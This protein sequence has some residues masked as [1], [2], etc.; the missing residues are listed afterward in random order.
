MN[1]SCLPPANSKSQS[2]DASQAV[3]ACN[4]CKLPSC[5]LHEQFANAS[6]CVVC[7]D[8]A[9]PVHCS[10]CYPCS[11]TQSHPLCF[12]TCKLFVPQVLDQIRD[13]SI[14]FEVDGKKYHILVIDFLQSPV[15]INSWSAVPWQSRPL[16]YAFVLRKFPLLFDHPV[17]LAGV[18][19]RIRNVYDR[20]FAAIP[21]PQGALDV[22]IEVISAIT[23]SF[24]TFKEL[25]SSIGTDAYELLMNLFTTVTKVL[26]GV[27]V[28]A[29]TVA[30]L[31]SYINKQAVKFGAT[32][33]DNSA[34][35]TDILIACIKMMIRVLCNYRPEQLAMEVA[36]DLLNIP[37]LHKLYVYF[38]T[39]KPPTSDSND[40]YFDE[41]DEEY[42][43]SYYNAYPQSAGDI[44]AIFA[45]TLVT[46]INYFRSDV[47]PTLKSFSDLVRVFQPMFPKE[48]LDICGITK[49][50]EIVN[51]V[52]IDKNMRA[53]CPHSAGLVDMLASYK[54]PY[55]PWITTRIRSEYHAA[56]AEISAHPNRDVATYWKSRIGLFS[57]YLPKDSNEPVDR[58]QPDAF[59]FHGAPGQGKSVVTDK[60]LVGALRYC[61]LKGYVPED[62]TLSTFRCNVSCANK[63]WDS[64]VGQ[65]V[66]VFNDFLQQKESPGNT[67]GPLFLTTVDT[68]PMA[69]PI[70][71]ANRKGIPV[72][73]MVVLM[74]GNI[75]VNDW[76]R[77][78]TQSNNP[79]A[80]KRRVTYRISVEARKKNVT[81]TFEKAPNFS[82]DDQWIFN[83]VETST[84]RSKTLRFADILAL[85][86][87][88]IE[89][90]MTIPNPCTMISAESNDLIDYL[91]NAS[92]SI[93]AIFSEREE[94]SSTE[95]NPPCPNPSAPP[96]LSA[97][98]DINVIFGPPPTTSSLPRSYLS[99]FFDE[100]MDREVEDIRDGASTPSLSEYE[101]TPHGVPNT[102]FK[103]YVLA[104]FAQMFEDVKKSVGDFNDTVAGFTK[105]APLVGTHTDACNHHD[106][107]H[108]RVALFEDAFRIGC[109]AFLFGTLAFLGIKKAKEI[110]HPMFGKPDIVV[111]PPQ[112][113]DLP[114]IPGYIVETITH[115]G[116]QVLIYRKKPAV[117][118]PNG[119]LLQDDLLK[120]IRNPM[121]PD[122]REAQIV[123]SLAQSQ[124][125][126][127][128]SPGGSQVCWAFFVNSSHFIIANHCWR[129]EMYVPFQPSALLKI[130]KGN[131]L[132][133][134]DKDVCLIRVLDN[135]VPGCR[136]QVTKFCESVTSPM[137]AIIPQLSLDEVFTSSGIA[138]P[139]YLDT[140][141]YECYS[142][143]RVGANGD[144]GLVY[145]DRSSS[146]P[147]RVLGI[148]V[149]GNSTTSFVA[150]VLASW[151]R[152]C[153]KETIA[154]YHPD[155]P[156]EKH[157]LST[158]GIPT[159]P[160]FSPIKSAYV[161]VVG[162]SGP[163]ITHGIARLGKFPRTM[164]D[165][166]VVYVS[167]LINGLNKWALKR[168]NLGNFSM[169]VDLLERMK[170]H[171]APIFNEAWLPTFQ[172]SVVSH[173]DRMWKA[174]DRSKAAGYS[175]VSA[176]KRVLFEDSEEPVLTAAALSA[177]DELEQ[178]LLN[179]EPIA[180][181]KVVSLKDEKLP[182]QKVIEGRTRLFCS[183][184]VFEFLLGR[185]YF[186]GLVSGLNKNGR[187]YGYPCATDPEQLGE[188]LSK[189]KNK[190][191]L[192]VDIKGQDTSYIADAWIYF[193]MVLMA[194]PAGRNFG[195]IVYNHP[196][197][198]PMDAVNYIRYQLIWHIINDPFVANRWAFYCGGLL[199]SGHLLTLV[200]NI[201]NSSRTKLLLQLFF[202][203]VESI[204]FGDDSWFGFDKLEDAQAAVE[205]LLK[206][207]VQVGF[208][209]VDQDK[210]DQDIQV[211][212][213]ENAVFCGRRF[214][215]HPI[216]GN[217][218]YLIPER[219]MKSV[220]FVKSTDYWANLRQSLDNFALES[221]R[222]PQ[223]Y[224]EEV[225]AFSLFGVCVRDYILPWQVGGHVVTGLS[226][227]ASNLDEFIRL[228]AIAADQEARVI[229]AEPQGLDD[230]VSV[231]G[232]S[233]AYGDFV[234]TAEVE[235]V[236][237]ADCIYPQIESISKERF[238]TPVYTEEISWNAA[239]AAGTLIHDCKCLSEYFDNYATGQYELA[240]GALFR[241]TVNVHVTISV[242]A[243][244]S[245]TLIVAAAPCQDPPIDQYAASTLIHGQIN[246][247]TDSTCL[248]MI[249]YQRD[250]LYSQITA[251][252]VGDAPRYF[253]WL[254]I[255]FTVLNPLNTLATPTANLLLSVWFSDIEF[256]K[257][258]ITTFVPTPQGPSKDDKRVGK[259]AVERV[260]TTK[261]IGIV[262]GIKHFTSGIKA[263]TEA[264]L[265]ST[266]LIKGLV[267]L[268]GAVKEV[269]T[270]VSTASAL[271][272]LAGL[273]KP[274]CENKIVAISNVGDRFLVNYDGVFMG[275]NVGFS[276]RSANVIPRGLFPEAP[277]PM[278]IATIVGRKILLTTF[279]WTTED[280]AQ[281]V[282]CVIPITPAAYSE[283]AP[284]VANANSLYL[285]SQLFAFWRG[286]LSYEI[287]PVKTAQHFGSMMI[288]VDHG[289]TTEM[290]TSSSRSSNLYRVAWDITS[291]SSLLVTVPFTMPYIVDTCDPRPITSATREL[292]RALFIAN[293]TALGTSPQVPSEIEVNVYVWMKNPEFMH[294]YVN[295]DVAVF[296][297][298]QGREPQV[299][300]TS[301][302]PS[303]VKVVPDFSYLHPFFD[304]VSASFAADLHRSILAL[305]ETKSSEYVDVAGFYEYCAKMK[306]R[307]Q[308]TILS[309]NNTDGTLGSLLLEGPD[310][311]AWS[312]SF[313]GRNQKHAKSVLVKRAYQFLEAHGY[314]FPQGKVDVTAT[315]TAIFDSAAEK[316][317]A[318]ILGPP[319]LRPDDSQFQ[320]L[321]AEVVYNLR[322]QTRRFLNAGT[323]APGTPILMY[324]YIDRIPLFFLISRLF[325][326]VTG[327]SRFNLYTN[328]ASPGEI[329]FNY[330]LGHPGISH[331]I[332]PLAD[333]LAQIQMPMIGPN[334]LYVI[335]G[336]RPQY[337]F[338]IQGS[339]TLRL[340][341]AAGDDASFGGVHAAPR[342]KVERYTPPDHVAKLV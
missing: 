127:Y 44:I 279:R 329:W 123:P 169:P 157:G 312:D 222:M 55:A 158:M 284:G 277:D 297:K 56:L 265:E 112:P 322:Q 197:I 111:A 29:A 63:H 15:G 235:E 90:Y 339:A 255:T 186:A 326:F 159:R 285:I 9:N 113:T 257:G 117:G 91:I 185:K 53:E 308:F 247:G 260:P 51:G 23:N 194:T 144:C 191:I 249:P 245:G 300:D 137:F 264:A 278:D 1:F 129:E 310:D 283:F 192:S 291:D 311:L 280:P 98:Q 259:E 218:A 50:M 136:S 335:R 148:H 119:L 2:I 233:E 108:K 202:T 49:F 319:S 163:P 57:G 82:D 94:L 210:D 252:Q 38:V 206:I 214:Y 190:Y 258:A 62:T 152:S 224:Y 125:P 195:P 107:Y 328:A 216:I 43:D 32:L 67:L 303:V 84:N 145:V 52:D 293:S 200:F 276:S 13:G 42:Y 17:V 130:H 3:K 243:L 225:T 47:V 88:S 269:G 133:F 132:R 295:T 58:K 14:D 97:Q 24:L 332:V 226:A 154:T 80:Y 238:T 156:A 79:G 69:A 61:K 219:L 306:I 85:L 40:F 150:P 21:R 12:G 89:R 341:F 7:G 251:Y 213:I 16:A 68:A 327:S 39:N 65:P 106:V 242:S 207:G 248:L 234:T 170:A 274:E 230:A 301:D 302:Q 149:A 83:V 126:V 299:P 41:S 181:P 261:D 128:Y 254:R 325:I 321:S 205:V 316:K 267:T 28:T 220:Q 337:Y 338:I 294:A 26:N 281:S 104:R 270:M 77:F 86:I 208:T 101:A 155:I 110:I 298:P 179:S 228:V 203:D 187:R 109:M 30:D 167:P 211:R 48:A 95:S 240:G 76:T 178:C 180:F 183:C 134:V 100:E 236:T 151:L 59:F 93:G 35:I 5:F 290:V 174:L 8:A 37:R 122:Q 18:V 60:L 196:L 256:V 81:G 166:S 289:I 331:P 227:H 118:E 121:V 333:P 217:T 172:E 246:A 271:L 78:L 292:S 135:L 198:G 336:P 87:R 96:Q 232:S 282:K 140:E 315:T 160:T 46:G 273:S 74:S 103:W 244:Q 323:V 262:R 334:H 229:S 162:Y 73:P 223:E 75:D 304:N 142:F 25:I 33:A 212:T 131:S 317:H 20:K 239:D 6:F 141:P 116:E 184:D 307:V 340:F 102:T 250:T 138:R 19:K 45:A 164:P 146:R 324:D 36:F 221:Y 171:W 286:E 209:Y 115:K 114:V 177:L 193:I 124:K 182:L 34:V 31:V 105:C 143:S 330:D 314:A 204:L 342:L 72:A 199:P 161:P 71:Q 66:V 272:M 4:A 201:F 70:A 296:A 253:D 305:C 92:D 10:D 241:A 237:E 64:F 263:T 22:L 173:P 288:S 189:F 11:C 231:E 120:M 168:A 309:S 176:P 139:K 153:V 268:G 287:Q 320:Y 266:N 147:E 175:F 165:G 188:M 54:P 318:Y 313:Q 99:S 27:A 275:H 215:E